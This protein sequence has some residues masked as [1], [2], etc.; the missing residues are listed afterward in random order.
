M[1]NS[2]I[3][4]SSILAPIV[5]RL[6][7]I[8]GRRNFFLVADAL[9]VVGTAYVY[10]R[11]RT[12]GY[13][14]VYAKYGM[15]C[16]QALAIHASWR[17]AFWL[18]FILNAIALVLVF[19]LHHPLH[20]GIRPGDESRMKQILKL[21]YVGTVLFVAGLT[22]L[23]N[24]LLF[25]GTS[26]AWGNVHVIALIVIGCVLLI[27]L[28]FWEAYAPLEYPF[29]P[30][31]LFKSFRGF[32]I[33]NF[34]VFLVGMCYYSAQ[35]LWPQEIQALFTTY[36]IEVGWYTAAIGVGGGIFGPIIGFSNQ[37]V[38]Y[39]RWFLVACVLGLTFSSGL[40]A[41]VS[42]DSQAGS[43]A[44]VVLVGIFSG[45]TKVIT[46]SMI[47]LSVPY[48]YIGTATSIAV[49]ALAVGGSVGT[50]IHTALLLNNNDAHLPAAV[51]QSAKGLSETSLE[52]L[53]EVISSGDTSGALSIPG[54]TSKILIAADEAVKQVS[55]QAFQRVYLVSIA[56][57]AIGAIASLFTLDLNDRMTSEVT[58]HID[59]DRDALGRKRSAAVTN[60]P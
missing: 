47:S 43:T 10:W 42:P 55:S 45:G 17:W 8:F 36:R 40:G 60:S 5:G 25:G 2:F 15:G 14:A 59:R 46:T 11:S 22:I 35:V 56:F 18:V 57:S 32:T 21:N 6:G 16:S 39:S 53:L 27:A 48:E 9:G 28:G 34:C 37:K 58:M 29:F 13:W 1:A 12:C 38:G 54:V 41:I 3:L 33:P 51:A 19:L 52:S 49:M 30:L 23:L 44:A 4:A 7:D 50:T 26:Y 31:S 24:G 20:Q